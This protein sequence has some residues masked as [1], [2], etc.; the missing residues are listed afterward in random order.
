[1]KKK[2]IAIIVAV[3]LLTVGFTAI[4]IMADAA[5]GTITHVQ[6]TPN[7]VTLG[8]GTQHNISPPR[9]WTKTINRYLMSIISG[10]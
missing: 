5:A 10:L 1:M 4:P 3:A 9:P 8:H 2:I 6:I 7:N